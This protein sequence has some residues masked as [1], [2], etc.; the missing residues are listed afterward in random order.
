MVALSSLHQPWLEIAKF[1]VVPPGHQSKHSNV[2]YNEFGK[3][4]QHSLIGYPF[5]LY[6]RPTF[7]CIA[8]KHIQ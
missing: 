2:Q 1:Q 6:E 3:H 5:R 8:L 7:V 4:Y